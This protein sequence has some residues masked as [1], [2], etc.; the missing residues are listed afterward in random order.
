MAYWGGPNRRVLNSKFERTEIHFFTDGFTAVV[1]VL[2]LGP[3]SNFSDWWSK[4]KADLHAVEE[5]TEHAAK[6]TDLHAVEKITENYRKLQKKLMRKND[7]FTINMLFKF[8]KKENFHVLSRQL[9]L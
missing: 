7:G 6:I 2:A 3:S 5:I 8:A 4:A 9:I 1:V